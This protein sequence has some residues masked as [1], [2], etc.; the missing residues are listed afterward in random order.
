MLIIVS[1]LTEY[2]DRHPDSDITKRE[3]STNA[4]PVILGDE[5][6]G[7]IRGIISEVLTSSDESIPAKCGEPSLSKIVD[8]NIEA[9]LGNL[10]LFQ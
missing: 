4:I 1:A 5:M 10:E 8:T 2:M 3:R 6:E 9:I 7:V